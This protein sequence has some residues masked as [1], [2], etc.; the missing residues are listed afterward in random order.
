MLLDELKK[1]AEIVDILNKEGFAV[2]KGKWS[3]IKVNKAIEFFRLTQK[4]ITSAEQK[5]EKRGVYDHRWLAGYP[6][7]RISQEE[8]LS[9]YSEGLPVGGIT[10]GSSTDKKSVRFTGASLIHSVLGVSQIKDAIAKATTPEQREQ[11]AK[12]KYGDK[13]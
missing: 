7:T 9:K 4:K 10:C 3:S 12:E 2:D 5:L 6:K 13:E 8:Y 11:A 1:P